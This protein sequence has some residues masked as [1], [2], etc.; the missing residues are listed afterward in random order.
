MKVAFAS[1]ENKGLASVI[2]SRFG[3]AKYFVIVDYEND[4]VKS[5]KVEVNPGSEA[6]GGAGIKAVQKL[7]NERVDVAVAGSFGPNA[8]TALEEMGIKHVEMS[9]IA[10]EQALEKLKD[11]I[12]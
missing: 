2:S 1:E 3:R 12:S 7:V 9:G 8:M 5:H 10:V 4:Q 6:K 11:L